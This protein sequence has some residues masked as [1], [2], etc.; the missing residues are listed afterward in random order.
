MSLFLFLPFP[1]KKI[2][3]NSS[4]RTK[5]QNISGWAWKLSQSMSQQA[6]ADL[7]PGSELAWTQGWTPREEKGWEQRLRMAAA[8]MERE[9]VGVPTGCGSRFLGSGKG[10]RSC[11]RGM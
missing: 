2:K 6:G 4:T 10:W 8:G 1:G 5:C 7:G 9:R 3:W 11:N